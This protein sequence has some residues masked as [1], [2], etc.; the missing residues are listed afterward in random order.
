MLSGDRAEL[1][2]RQEERKMSRFMQFA[3]SAT[4]E[5]LDDAGWH[6]EEEH[7]KEMTVGSRYSRTLSQVESL[8]N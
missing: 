3:V 2:D 1:D 8:Y 6:P 4:Q 7:D 5:A